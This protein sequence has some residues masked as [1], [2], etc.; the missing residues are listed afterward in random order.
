MLAADPVPG[1]DPPV[2]ADVTF[3]FSDIEGSTALARRLGDGYERVLKEHRRLLRSAFAQHGGDEH[4]TEGDSFF[5]SFGSA[6]DAVAGA[7]SAQLALADH[8]WPDGGVVRV[9][10]GIHCGPATATG[11]GFVGVAVHQ[12]ARV[13]AAAHG[14]QV[15]VSE[16][17]RAAVADAELPAK[18]ALRDLGSHPLRDFERAQHLFQVV[19]P[20]LVAD[21]PPVRT[22]AS[23]PDVVGD[24]DDAPAAAA[25]RRTRVLLV[26]DQELLRAGFRMILESRGVDVAGE[27][28]DGQQA[29]DAVRRLQPDVVLM[30]VRMPNVDGIEATRRLMA[31]EAGH[32]VRVLILT[33]FGVDEVVFEALRAGASGFLLKDTPPDDLVAGVEVVA[34]GEALLSPSVT[35]RLIE[36]FAVGA[37]AATP[38]ADPATDPRLAGLTARE[39]EVLTLVARG[40]SNTEI[41]GELFVSEATVKTHVGSLFSKL[42]VRDRV[43]AVVVAYETGLVR[44]GG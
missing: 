9:R 42:G 11:S 26:D 18:V 24:G 35:R 23:L 36:E 33:T 12:A 20:R 6:A 41:A 13:C 2:P 29:I 21:H 38:P 32:P 10:I 17:V 1:D 14:G 3:L 27:A 7:L 16:A 19:H 44:P 39:I 4:G 37:S 43:Q 25:P 8:E 28:A 5:V 30:D 15:L 22:S 31:G 34:R 40:R